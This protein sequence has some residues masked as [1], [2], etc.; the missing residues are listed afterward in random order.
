MNYLSESEYQ[1]Y[2]IEATTSTAS[3]AAVS[4]LID[5]HCRRSTLAVAK[6]CERLRIVSGSNTVRLS[7]LPA[8][9]VAPATSPIVSV[10]V[11]FGLPRRGERG[12]TDDLA[13]AVAVAF[14]LPGTWSDL[15]PSAVDL[16][17][18]TGE[19]TISGNP[20]GIPFNEIEITYTAGFSEIPDPVK[21]A[22]AQLIR[23]AQAT[24]ALNVRA[25]TMDRMQIDYFSD[26]LLDE[27]VQALLRPFVAQ[28]VG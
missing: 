17:P 7:Y 16:A 28:K 25:Q 13:E 19:L 2:G 27:V 14:G 15:S 11:R 26:S 10:R 22:C 4:A 12:F 8:V 3:V 21:F 1:E 6:Y 24:P 23:N 5:T 18:E 20:L 9:A